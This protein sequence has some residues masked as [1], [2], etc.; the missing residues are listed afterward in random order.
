MSPAAVENPPLSGTL[1]GFDFGERRLGVAVGETETRLA[2]PVAAIAQE[3]TQARL[4]AI[5][6]LV[7]EWRPA[8]FVVGLPHHAD[9]G[10][11][12]VARLASKFARRLQARFGLPVAFVD[13]TLTSVEAGARIREAGGVARGKG[14]I[15][16]HAAAV[17]LQSYLDE[18]LQTN[19]KGAHG[20]T[21]A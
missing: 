17:I 13:E 1:L 19:A 21:P 9:G 10:D 5:E 4:A 15:D 20:R 16:A 8:G 14:E 7:A 3:S 18:T 6:R 11:H 2:H 12:E